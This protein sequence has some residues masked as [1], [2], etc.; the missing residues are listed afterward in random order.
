MQEYV[1]ELPN[2]EYP[3]KE[4]F[5]YQNNNP[6][7][8]GNMHF[9]NSYKYDTSDCFFFDLIDQDCKEANELANSLGL[10]EYKFTKVLAGGKMPAHIDPFRTGVLMLPL[11][12]EPSPIIFYENG[13]ETFRYT[14]TGPT[15]INAKIK[16]GVPEVTRDRIFLQINLKEPW[17]DILSTYHSK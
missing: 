15:I 7:Y 13:E 12:D 17:N 2:L 16:H 5:D 4:L 8:K 11:T 1:I 14:Y 6:N 3:R 9:Q 10:E